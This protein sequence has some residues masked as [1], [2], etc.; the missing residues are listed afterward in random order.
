MDTTSLRNSNVITGNIQTT[1]VA[2]KGW[3][4]FTSIPNVSI[5]LNDNVKIFVNNGDLVQSLTKM[6]KVTG[7]LLNHQSPEFLK[8]HQMLKEAYENYR[9]I[10]AI[11]LSGDQTSD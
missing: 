5:T 7:I 6:S 9:V 11:V 3:S 1:V 8:Q 2:S 10:E 4:K